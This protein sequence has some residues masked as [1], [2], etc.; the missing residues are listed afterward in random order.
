VPASGADPGNGTA[1]LEKVA[2]AFEKFCAV[3]MAADLF[4]TSRG[5]GVE[6]HARRYISGLVSGAARKNME[7]MNQRVGSEEESDYEGMQHFLSGSPWDEQAVYDFIAQEADGRLGGRADSMLIIDESGFSK[8]GR[9]S[10]GVAR[11]YNGRLGKQDNCQVGVFSVLNC[12]THSVPVGARLFLPDEWAGDEARCLKAGV[13]EEGIKSRTKI[14]QARELIEQAVKQGL[15]FGCVGVDAFYGRDSGLLEWINDQGLVYCADVPAN[16]LVFERRPKQ[17]QRPAR[18]VKAAMRVDKLAAKLAK[19]KG[20]FIDLREGE[21]GMV[22]A[23]MW[24]KRV[25]V[26]P[27]GREQPRECWLVVRRTADSALKISLSNAPDDTPLRR[28][29]LWQGSRF[30]VER[31]FQDGKSH[32]GMAQYQARGWRAWHHHM[33]M[34]SLALLF[35]MEQRLLLGQH[36]PLLSAADI[37][38]LLDWRLARP[39]TEIQV[40]AS[41]QTR[42]RQRERNAFNAQNRM[43]EKIGRCKKRKPRLYNLPK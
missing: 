6:K 10:V 11:Q 25:W 24:S 8:K 36:A 16:A 4:A 3:I 28:L 37:V 40:V 23:E 12:G 17:E 35:M 19:R 18:M 2:K 1:G 26:W 5:A 42:H 38:E 43:R 39:R 22:R 30:F 20:R 29:A 27:A 33:A 41:I 34:V 31:A 14:E 9:D 15:R 7:C 32:A 21:N 13:P